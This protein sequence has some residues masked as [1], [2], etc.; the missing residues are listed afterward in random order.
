MGLGGPGFF[1]A[2]KIPDFDHTVAAPAG[3]AFQGLGVLGHGIDAIDMAFSKLSDEGGGEHAFNLG[4]I[5][6]SSVLSSSFKWVESWVEISRL[7]SD[8][9]SR[10]LV[11]S[12]RSRERFDFLDRI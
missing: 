9:G 6:R 1:A 2:G 8:T 11:R 4:G 5:E 7:P 10:C 12:S 3:E